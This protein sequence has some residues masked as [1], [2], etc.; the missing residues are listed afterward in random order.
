MRIFCPEFTHLKSMDA[1]DWEAKNCG[2]AYSGIF[3][4]VTKSIYRWKNKEARYRAM[5]NL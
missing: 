3:Y 1:M 2:P 5:M 4:P